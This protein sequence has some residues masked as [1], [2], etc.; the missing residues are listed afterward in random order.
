MSFSFRRREHRGNLSW[1]LGGSVSGGRGS[2][3]KATAGS[4]KHVRRRKSKHSWTRV[5][6]C[7]TGAA[8]SSGS[9]AETLSGDEVA[10]LRFLVRQAIAEWQ[11]EQTDR[12]A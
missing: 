5:Q 6:K 4:T 7:S 10:F 3:P 1:K 12:A 11:R 9:P 8:T 2:G